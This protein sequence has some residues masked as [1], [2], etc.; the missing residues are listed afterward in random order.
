[1]H[2]TMKSTVI[3]N[4]NSETPSQP[5]HPEQQNVNANQ[6]NNGQPNNDHSRR[7]PQFRVSFETFVRAQL[8][9]HMFDV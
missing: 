6:A 9:L 8:S 2:E 5:P 4:S 1:M 7:F 3:N